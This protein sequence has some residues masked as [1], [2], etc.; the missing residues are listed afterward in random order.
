MKRAA[1]LLVVLLLAFA[2]LLG[3]FAARMQERPWSEKL[4][5]VP[6]PEVL[7]IVT[8]DQKTLTAAFLVFR[9][10][11]YYGGLP[12]SAPLPGQSGP[13]FSGM[14]RILE[15]AVRLDPYNLDAYY[16]AQATL[17]WDLRHFA[18]ANALLDYG[19]QHRTW[20]YYLPI[21]AGFNAAYFMKDYKSA[22]RYYRRAGELTG[23]DLFMTLSGRY[24]YETGETE[25]AIAYLTMM[26]KGASND[27]IRKSLA[28]RL[29]AFQAVRKIEIARDR[30]RQTH[31]HLPTDLAILLKS[32]DLAALPLDPYGG[33]FYIATDGKVRSTSGFSATQ[34]DKKP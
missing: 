11:M 18:E 12:E 23:A 10:M 34:K 7:R 22:A 31:G 20:D 13:D 19:M 26:V 21:F 33:T 28:T 9:T 1:L 15:A 14:E 17:V 3:P 8:T 30:Y 16:F 6:E 29:E 24:L 32:G 27:A 5:Y 25:Q 4:G 2:T